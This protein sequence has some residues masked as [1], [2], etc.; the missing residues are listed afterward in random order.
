M[1]EVGIGILTVSDTCSRG[2]AVDTSGNN[3]QVAAMASAKLQS[4][5][6]LTGTILS[7]HDSHIVSEVE[8]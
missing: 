8:R 5:I 2:E 6:V 7:G 1:V 3:L 4:L